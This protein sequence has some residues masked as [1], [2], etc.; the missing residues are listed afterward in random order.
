MRHPTGHTE[1]SF[2]IATASPGLSSA[3]GILS[4]ETDETVHAERALPPRLKRADGLG[5]AEAKKSV[6]YVSAKI[7]KFDHYL[8]ISCLKVPDRRL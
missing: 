2:G 8:M 3:T 4:M 6:V 5:L 1:P 7:L